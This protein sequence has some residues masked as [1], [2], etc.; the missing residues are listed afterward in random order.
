MIRSARAT[1]LLLAA[2]VAVVPF[3]PAAHAT[4]PPR[5]TVTELSTPAGSTSG[6]NAIS[7]SGIVAG[8]VTGADSVPHAARWSAAGA[9]T[10]LG[11][12]PGGSTSIANGVNDSGQVAGS[13]DRTGGGYAYPVRWSAAGAIQ[14][15]GGTQTNRLGQG[16]AIDA[17]G[18][19]AGGQR[20]ANSEGDPYGI[21]YGVDGTPTALGDVGLARG[22]N[23]RGQVVGGPGPYVWQSGTLTTLPG[24]PG[25]GGGSAYGINNAGLI[26]GIAGTASGS[27]AATWR[28]GAIT[29]IGTVDGI[30]FSTA[31][32]V[33]AAGQ[34]VGTSDPLCSPCV[35]P[36]AWIWQ[37]GTT[38]TALDTLV[39]AGSGWTLRE[40]NGI[41]DRG[42]IV[43][44]GL[45]NGVLR[46]Y[47]LTP[48]RSANVNFAP[49]GAA[50]PAGYV[51]DTGAAY[52][53]R[54]GG[55]SY[56]WN[57]DNTANARDRNAAGSPDQRYDTLTH[58][59]KAGGA[60]TWELAVPNGTY[61]VH[62]VAGDPI[63][64]DSTYRIAVEGTVTAAGTPTT[65]NHWV[66]GTS[67]VT[68]ADGRL[69][70]TN[71]SGAA[72]NKIDYVDVI[73]G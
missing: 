19:V 34:V 59:Q 3:A 56:G 10:D 26:V 23:G 6:A 11:G 4:A 51:A 22:I 45:H 39:P 24:L 49:S 46:G 36:R 73:A 64:T 32:A 28:N 12:L 21:L 31:R 63:N 1:V 65:T 16:L 37:S 25:G 43:G 62:V 41:N 72:N 15:L 33:N 50:L 53:T 69:T 60:T 27:H 61:T 42:E 40:A 35:A 8:N 18:R 9:R 2:S 44:V 38:I 17:S 66:E 13:A 58:M 54:G 70:I 14:D 67:R 57:I 68:V 7:N 20:P 55:L 29:D 47:R 30:Q 71:A 48:T 52:G 5:Y